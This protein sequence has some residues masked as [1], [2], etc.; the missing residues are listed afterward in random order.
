M[1]S[2]TSAGPDTGF[3]DRLHRV[4][5]ARAPIEAAKPEI[6]VL[7]DWKT[8]ISGVSGVFFAV[9]SGLIAVLIVRIAAFHY[10]G[11][12]MVSPTPDFTLAMETAAAFGVAILLFRLTPF[13]GVKYYFLQFA[14][15]ALAISTMHNAVHAVPAAFSAAFSP[16]WTASV[17]RETE[18]NSLYLRGEVMPFSPVEEAES[19]KALPRVFRL[20]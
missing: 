16:E 10:V 11:I 19:E 5:E 8:N 9:L 15:V 1:S 12:A 6:A 18:P 13:R 3:Q 7:P 20:N 2:P 14:G 4:A 17:L